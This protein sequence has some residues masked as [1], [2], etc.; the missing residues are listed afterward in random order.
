MIICNKQ[1]IAASTA[2]NQPPKDIPY[3]IQQTDEKT[4]IKN[5]A[6]ESPDVELFFLDF[7]NCGRVDTI[8]KNDPNAPD[9]NCIDICTSTMYIN[10][11][12]Y[13]ILYIHK[14]NKMLPI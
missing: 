7:H 1:T 4:F 11:K 10:T 13:Y 14:L 3:N 5:I 8:D 12:F 2:S 9:N 6:G